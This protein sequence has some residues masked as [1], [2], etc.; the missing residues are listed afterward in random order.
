[1]LYIEDS[2]TGAILPVVDRR[3]TYDFNA[4]SLHKILLNEEKIESL[5]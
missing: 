2:V 3:P 4:S 5:F 1:M